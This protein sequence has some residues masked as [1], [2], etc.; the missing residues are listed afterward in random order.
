MYILILWLIPSLECKKLE[1]EEGEH[2]R[3]RGA[4][5]PAPKFSMFFT[6]TAAALR[7]P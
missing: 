3:F 6:A 4:G 5:G 2:P 7:C 1:G